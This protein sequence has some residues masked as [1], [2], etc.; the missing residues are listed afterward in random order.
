M[1]LARHAANSG[2]DRI[3]AVGGDGT[4]NEVINGVLSSD[5][6]DIPCL[7]YPLGTANDWS[8]THPAPANIKELKSRLFSKVS[9][10]IDVGEI[11]FIDNES[12]TSRLFVNI[13]DAGMGAQVVRKVNERSKWMGAGLTFIRAILE[14]FISYENVPANVQMDDV[15]YDGPVRAIIIANGKFFGS[16]MCIAPDAEPDDGRFAVVI[17]GNVSV[18]DYLRYLPRIQKGLHIHHPRVNYYH[19]KNIKIDSSHN[20]ELEA[21][22]EYLGRVPANIG[23]RPGIL[24]VL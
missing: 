8:R 15:N 10:K 18:I 14:T 21:D 4:W 16:G 5:N 22:G 24:T 20:L 9:R 2:T 3:M 23:I 1:Q 19:T 17:I 11:S 6:P 12:K 7:L 13:A